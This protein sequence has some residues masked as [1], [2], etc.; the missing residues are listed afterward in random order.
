MLTMTL[1]GARSR[2]STPSW[3]LGAWSS[4]ATSMTSWREPPWP[5]LRCSSGRGQRWTVPLSIW[6]LS[7]A[8]TLRPVSSCFEDIWETE[9]KLPSFLIQY[10]NLSH[11]SRC[12]LM[13]RKNE[14]GMDSWVFFV[15]SCRRNSRVGHHRLRF[16]ETLAFW[17][18]EADEGQ[19]GSVL[20]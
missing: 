20:S 9:K 18:Q 8:L 12:G 6:R 10:D 19:A 16:V 5:C 2:S 3:I 7:L 17:W 4:V 15:P 1:S 11:Y 13:A 14:G